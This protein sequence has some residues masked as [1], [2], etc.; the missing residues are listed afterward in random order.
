MATWEK[1]TLADVPNIKEGDTL[2]AYQ[3]PAEV[4]RYEVG[5]SAKRMLV[6]LDALML[7]PPHKGGEKSNDWPPKKRHDRP[8][9]PNF[10][11]WTRQV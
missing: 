6:A 11:L 10:W 2:I 5:A 8:R 9:D 7:R 3:G 1:I 4:L